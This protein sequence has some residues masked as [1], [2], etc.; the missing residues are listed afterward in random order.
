VSKPHRV[1]ASN[2]VEKEYLEEINSAIDRVRKNSYERVGNQLPNFAGGFYAV[3]WGCG[4]DGCTALAVIN[5]RTGKIYGPPPSGD[6]TQTNFIAT[7]GMQ[8]C[9]GIN[10]QPNSTLIV[11]TRTVRQRNGKPYCE[12]SF[13]DWKD[14]HYKLVARRSKLSPDAER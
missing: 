9:A 2:G 10:F 4:T 6:P 7:A 8:S 3:T 13:Y 11:V 12:S 14:G 1:I 5:P